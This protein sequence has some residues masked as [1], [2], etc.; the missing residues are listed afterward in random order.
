VSKFFKAL[1]KLEQENEARE[2]GSVETTTVATAAPSAAVEAP[3]EPVHYTPRV[4]PRPERPAPR[5]PTPERTPSRLEPRAE[6]ARVEPRR[7]PRREPRVEPTVE[8]HVEPSVE[9]S[10]EAG[11]EPSVETPAPPM[12]EPVVETSAATAVDERPEPVT[13]TATAPPAH[14]MTYGAP[15]T[16]EASAPRTQR[17]AFVTD[18]EPRD[19]AEPGE[20][21]DHLV[22]VLEPTSFAAEQYR[23][24]R[25]AIETF[26]RERGTR[27]VGV[28][29]PG[30]GDGK[31]ITAINLAGALAQAPDARVLLVDADL[32]HPGT[33]K[34]LGLPS[35]R[36]LS[37]YLL[38]ARTTVDEIVER[39]AGLTFAVIPAGPVS[40]MPYELL[41]SPRLA[42]LLA[43]LRERFDYVV[44][45]TPSVLPFPDVGI[46]RDAVDGFVMI[47][48]AN[49]TTREL[50]RESLNTIGRPRTLGLIYNDDDRS[51][52]S[53][54]GDE[55][56]ESGWKRYFAIGGARG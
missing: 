15:V 13:A 32:R 22:S 4:P 39:P 42:S 7:E 55:G 5:V 24:A 52:I 8:S 23:A 50:L 18:V 6:P 49:R 28:S 56:E 17:Q 53:L 2:S 45:D 11:V 51:A 54:S 38:D 41:K 10:V 30:R 33:A 46:L 43:A 34:Y 14:A 31:T 40:S 25:L 36:G 19:V 27:I 44:V 29:S 26:G 20:L 16:R 47:V 35:G 37:T 21:D 9:A 1:E 12:I 48:R 3:P